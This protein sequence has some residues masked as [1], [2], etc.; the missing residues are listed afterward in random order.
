MFMGQPKKF[1]YDN[2]IRD[3]LSTMITLVKN[4]KEH[5]RNESYINENRLLGYLN[6]PQPTESSPLSNLTDALPP[7]LFSPSLF[8]PLTF[9][10]TFYCQFSILEMTR[11]TFMFG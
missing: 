3:L 1:R 10:V 6:R 7:P 9:Y 5:I 4:H 8:C 2:R 11:N